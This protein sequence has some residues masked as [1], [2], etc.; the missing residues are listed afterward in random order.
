MKHT[1]DF[2][3][4][5]IRM[6]SFILVVLLISSS[7]M[8]SSAKES[9][10][11]KNGMIRVNLSSLNYPLH[12][13]IQICGDYSLNSGN[14]VHSLS[15][16]STI[17]I[18]MDQLTGMLT[19]EEN[20]WTSISS[21]STIR[22]LRHDS[23]HSEN[24]VKI[25]QSRYP[26][27]LYPASI[28][29]I[30]RNVDGVFKL[31]IIA[32][33]FIED[34]LY[35][36]LPYELGNGADLEA[37]KAQAIVS[38]TFAMRAMNGPATSLWDLVDT[39]DSQVYG[40][41]PE[42]NFSR[43]KQAV[44]ETK[45]YIL[46]YNNNYAAVYYTASNGG[47]TESIKNAW[48]STSYPYSTVKDDPFD[49]ASL[50]ARKKTFTVSKTGKQENEVL[51]DLLNQKTEEIFGAG[52]QILEVLDVIPHTPKYNA[53][54]RLYTLLDFS[55]KL[56]L[57]NGK[58]TTGNLTFDIF[59]DLEM[60]LEMSINSGKN[61]LWSVSEAQDSYTVNAR[62][63][64]HGIGMSQRG[65]IHMA[66]LG[67]T[68]DQI[69]N[70]YFE[71]CQLAPITLQRNVYSSYSDTP[72]LYIESPVKSLNSNGKIVLPL[73]AYTQSTPLLSS[74]SEQANALIQ[75]PAHACVSV[76]GSYNN[77]WLVQ[78]GSLWG[79]LPKNVLSDSVTVYESIEHT[80]TSLYG[81]GTV[82]NSNALNL[83]TGPNF[84][85]SIRTMIPVDTV[86]PIFDLSGNWAHVQFGI[87]EGYVSLD[88]LTV[89]RQVLPVTTP[90][91]I[92]SQTAIVQTKSGTLNLRE[93]ASSSARVLCTIPRL[94]E[95][96]VLD[97]GTTWCHV[98]YGGKTGF[99]M[100]EYL[101]FTQPMATF[102]P[103]PSIEPVQETDHAKVVTTNGSLNLRATQN[104]KVI[105]TIPR[106]EIIA[107]LNWGETWSKVNYNGYTGFVMTSYLVRYNPIATIA[108][109]L[110]PTPTNSS[111]SQQTKARVTTIQGPLNLRK[112]A[113]QNASILTKIPQYTEVTVL[114]KGNTW[115][116]VQYQS[117]IGY[118]M[119]SFLTFLE[120]TSPSPTQIVTPTSTP[121]PTQT[122]ETDLFARVLT[123]GGSLNMRKSAKDNAAVIR[124]I[125]R[126]ATV[127]VLQKGDTW[128]YVRY[129]TSEGYVMTKFLSFDVATETPVP[130]TATPLL[131]F[132]Y[133]TVTTPS[134]SLNMRSAA[135]S[136]GK[137]LGTIPKNT[138]I[139]VLEQG[140]SWCKILYN[141]QIGY[142]MTQYL[143]FQQ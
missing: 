39:T 135:N 38:R 82:T 28:S 59:N 136:T 108:P 31:Y 120:N 41:T 143:S 110:V 100:T 25:L 45:G 96:T 86:I 116:K 128:C 101:H 68:C 130:A 79:Y 117:T 63:Y 9:S 103:A 95:I 48:G 122:Q 16:G 133:A 90:V 56:Q 91:I 84:N 73:S 109:T 125:P 105:R 118:V 1:A 34:Y 142:V 52:T 72:T 7:C 51:N 5:K 78:Y 85:S 10:S 30:P 83:R 80:A 106:N 131:T 21:T 46:Q 115:C 20:S 74:P 89:S 57:Q 13:E 24:G 53:P 92:Q 69:L 50:Y 27:N 18:S 113:N 26:E 40:G 123:N 137:L 12:L 127:T 3:N 8:F 43:C 87:L 139:R 77:Y 42:Q 114:E 37:L 75:I 126:L 60:P 19:V 64:G 134:G 67:Y 61:E 124:T 102:T 119:T 138:Q 99:V 49:L 23:A 132:L 36:V 11:T 2:Q 29:L 88:Y 17:K 55:V 129:N 47:Q 112:N 140:A 93:S 35:G 54:S 76:Y 22:I 121:K 107:V 70:F 33:L 65:A 94:T 14:T 111:T 62:R 15:K 104:G 6:I 71:G 4:K 98:T 32:E 44:D 58:T 66:Q 97:R 81:Y 141:G